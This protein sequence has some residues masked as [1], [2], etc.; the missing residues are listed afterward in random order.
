MHVCVPILLETH[1]LNVVSS[2]IEGDFSG[3]EIKYIP[4]DVF[5]EMK[6]LKLI[7]LGIILTL[8]SVPS[9][10]GLTKLQYF[11]LGAPHMLAEL[12]PMDDLKS[13]LTLSLS[14]AYHLTQLPSLE[15]LKKLRYFSVTRRS[16]MCCNGFL[17]NG[18]CDLTDYR[19][20]PHVNETTVVCRNNSIPASEMAWIKAHTTGSICAK[21]PYDLVDVAPSYA[22]TDGACGGVMFRKCT[23]RNT[24]GI[25]FNTRMQVINCDTTGQYESIRRLEI[26]RNVGV[27]CDP[28]VEAWL[29]C[30]S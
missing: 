1:H 7:H 8:T 10:A 23:Y 11:A 2:H 6:S 12:P 16:E 17:S 21:V 25:C 27:P 14:E 30:T 5:S 24:S 13:L 18:V 9:L 19:C 15:K 4:N 29:G 20:K 28:S 26:A 3:R 22:S